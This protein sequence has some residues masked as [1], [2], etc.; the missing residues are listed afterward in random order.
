MST[1]LLLPLLW[2]GAAAGDPV[3][4]VLLLDDSGSMA[5]NDPDRRL[6]QGVANFLLRQDTD[7]RVGIIAFDGAPEVL[8][9]LTPISAASR[10]RLQATLTSVRYDGA[11]TDT[12]AA[13]E[14]ALYEL[15]T[16]GRPAAMQVIVLMTD[17]VIDTGSPGQDAERSAWL[18]TQLLQDAQREH[19]LIFGLA[20][21]EQADFQLLYQLARGTGAEYYRA[22]RAEDLH[23]ALESIDSA[24]GRAYDARAT[25]DAAPA[26][27]QPAVSAP[28]RQPV[29]E[30]A[31]T[32][33]QRSTAADSGGAT[34]ADEPV[35]ATE[36]AAGS[37]QPAQ[38]ERGIDLK[39][40]GAL[41]VFL[42]SV[43]WFLWLYSRQSGKT[44][45]L[46]RLSGGGMGGEVTTRGVLYDVSDDQDVKRYEL[47]NKVTIIGRVAG[48]DAERQYIVVRERTVG[49]HHA[50]MER[51]GDVYWI[52][53]ENSVNGTYVNDRRI[54]GAHPLKHGDNIRVHKHKFMFVI[55]SLIG[56]DQT[57][58][59]HDRIVDQAAS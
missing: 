51:R 38:P 13:V 59:E 24:L 15:R 52:T 23:H 56:S 31:R 30:P 29:R 20:F 27:T 48:T 12:A 46:R 32:Q 53:D 1:A 44:R 7:A 6:E 28:V 3:D 58:L 49:R 5:A 35:A 4:I 54:Y 50:S 18:E 57:L 2:P 22:N 47:G 40:V 55:P 11:H 9:P 21:S 34:S 45:L 8:A 33:P 16:S 42:M 17:G 25:A 41:I 43:A 14:R 10:L 36:E 37:A 26:T 19:V 39:V